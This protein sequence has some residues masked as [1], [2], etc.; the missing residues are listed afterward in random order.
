MPEVA[1]ANHRAIRSL[2][3]AGVQA[4]G[5]D[6]KEPDPSRGGTLTVGIVAPTQNLEVAPQAAAVVKPCRHPMEVPPRLA[7][8]LAVGI[9]SPT[10]KRC[11]SKY[12]ARMI[13][14]CAYGDVI[15]EGNGALA[16][17]IILAFSCFQGQSS[18]ERGQPCGVLNAKHKPSVAALLTIST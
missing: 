13:E 6:R 9:V 15:V 5:A 17:G 2:D 12:S 1:P 7:T 8:D 3:A 4:A 11:I 14:A 18:A 16:F 10:A